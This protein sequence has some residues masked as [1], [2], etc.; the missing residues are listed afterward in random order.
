MS[1]YFIANTKSEVRLGQELGRGGE[2]AVYPVEG[3][4]NRVA[5]IYNTLPDDA[6]ARKLSKMPFQA[7]PEL[8]AVAAWPTDLLAN[9]NGRT[10]GFLMPRFTSRRDAHELYGPKSR[11]DAFPQADFRFVSHVAANICRAF[12]LVHSK[13][14][15]IGDINH[16]NVLVGLDGTIVLIDCDS[17][18]IRSDSGFFSCDVGVPLFRSRSDTKS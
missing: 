13:G 7:S 5:K 11:A 9:P 3:Q 14:H 10:V 17:F 16:G 2:G 4:P 12:A 18:Q 6:K 8:L 15:V 1:R